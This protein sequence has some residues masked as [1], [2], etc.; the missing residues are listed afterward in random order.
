M[1]FHQHGIVEHAPSGT[2]ARLINLSVQIIRNGKEVARYPGRIR[3]SL[4]NDGT[5]LI[6][7]RAK[8]DLGGRFP[9]KRKQLLIHRALLS[10]ENVIHPDGDRAWGFR[11]GVYS[12][13]DETGE[14]HPQ[15]H[16]DFKVKGLYE[17]RW[18]GTR[19]LDSGDPPDLWKGGG[20]KAIWSGA[21]DRMKPV[22]IWQR[23]KVLKDEHHGLIGAEVT[24]GADG[25]TW[26]VNTHERL[27]AG[28]GA[29]VLTD[30]SWS[31]DTRIGFS[32]LDLEGFRVLRAGIT[33]AVAFSLEGE[34]LAKVQVTEPRRFATPLIRWDGDLVALVREH[35]GW[36]EKREDYDAATYVVTR[37][38]TKT[39]EPKGPVEGFPPLKSVDDELHLLVLGD[40]ALAYVPPKGPILIMPPREGAVERKSTSLVKV[41]GA[42]SGMTAETVSA[43]TPVG[44]DDQSSEASQLFSEMASDRAIEALL[45]ANPAAFAACADAA[46]DWTDDD[47]EAAAELLPARFQDLAFRASDGA[48]QKLRKR[49]KT[50]MTPVNEL[51]LKLLAGVGT[52]ASLTAIAELAR[53]SR[54]AREICEL[55]GIAIPKKGPAVERFTRHA[56]EIVPVVK[57][58]KK[59]VRV[60]PGGPTEAILRDP[61]GWTCRTPLAH[62]LSVEPGS[63]E[64]FPRMKRFH[65]F[66]AACPCECDESGERYEYSEGRGGK[67]TIDGANVEPRP[68]LDERCEGGKVKPA[69]GRLAWGLVRSDHEQAFESVGTIG[70]RPRWQQSPDGA[71]CE[72]CEQTMFYVGHV[73]ATTIRPH[74]APVWLYGFWCEG[75]RRG[76][77]IPQM[78]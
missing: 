49:I 22:T 60:I 66:G 19:T 42:P 67:L 32:T 38:D 52:K 75:C 6:D 5:L 28:R 72:G 68:S 14:D 2:I 11:T 18:D 4:A 16:K 9:Q 39:L 23:G 64:G 69:K 73:E 17:A 76:V 48:V 26:V 7:G 10:G 54:A 37:F 12:M 53:A 62:V 70:G 45:D 27:I 15:A 77:Q 33:G 36:N 51:R 13:T 47:L 24:I 65:W 31:E 50:K 41:L 71:M 78:T 43:S 55:M 56:H 74:V 30:I 35:D 20:R 58:V 59:D 44:S 25:K 8:I 46:C 61:A 3:L 34:V 40:G 29:N 57:G 63:L 21:L 1:A